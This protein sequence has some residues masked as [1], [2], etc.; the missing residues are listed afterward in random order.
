MLYEF[1]RDQERIFDSL[2]A[3]LH[4]VD[5]DLTFEF[6]PKQDGKREFVISAGG[7]REAFPKV[8]AL[9]AA[10]PALPNWTIVKFRPRRAPFDIRV[11]EK[12]VNAADVHVVLHAQ[13]EKVGL[14]VS[15]PGYKASEHTPYATIGY[16]FLDQTLG[17][18]D[19]ETR[20]GAI[21]FQAPSG[22]DTMAV[23]LHELPAAFDAYFARR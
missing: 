18:F 17:E 23:S 2:A 5:K 6:G 14:T 21:Q 20:V 7:I 22:S 13:G 8:E 12:G 1:E 19:V 15:I 4:K 3:Q 11:G 16:L 10:A 9:H